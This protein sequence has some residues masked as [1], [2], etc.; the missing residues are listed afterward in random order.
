MNSKLEDRFDEIEALARKMGLDPFPICFEEVPREVIWDVASYG[1]PTRMSHWSFGRTF[2]HQKTYGEMGYGKIYELIINNDPSYAFLD[3]TNP[4]IINLLVAAHCGAHADFFK[5]NICFAKTNRNMVNQAERNAKTI[6]QYKATYGLDAVEEWMDYAFSIDRHLDVHLGETREK[7]PEPE[8]VFRE[9]KPL[10]Y[11]DIMG[12]SSKSRV[13]EEIKNQEFPP[14]PEYDL[15]WFLANYAQILPWQREVLSIVRSE[16]YY[17]QPQLI[18][19]ILN[20]GW[21]S[22]WHA[23]LMLNYENLSAEEHLDFCKAHSGVVSPGSGG[24]L[25]PYYIG[26]RILTD[27]KKRW[28]EYYEK[29]LKDAA[30]L[31]GKADEAHD[32]KG[33]V[34]LSK[35]NG[36]Q[37]LF[38]IRAEEDDISFVHNYLTRDLA[39]EMELF[40]YGFRGKS[41]DPDE[42]DIII[43]DR[44][45]HAIKEALTSRLHHNGAPPIFIEKVDD[46]SVMHLR[47][48]AKDPVPLDEQY[49]K[50]TLRYVYAIW[51]KPIS[52]VTHDRF[53]AEVKYTCGESGATKHTKKDGETVRIQIEM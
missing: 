32:E 4:D 43:K 49:A 27:V 25:N 21:A 19:K 22:F 23:E 14:H 42:D 41:E 53:G 35:M 18:T 9:I 8:H 47:H 33:R 12:E 46:K 26:F 36:Y 40:T 51:K 2:T 24:S 20:E 38:K 5:H 10:P 13:T 45:L 50:E 37:K 15:L 48:H 44:G 30:F 52:L 17:F 6:E 3:D 31:A 16:A 7:Y 28:D 1:L 39:E 11:A 34:C 29:G